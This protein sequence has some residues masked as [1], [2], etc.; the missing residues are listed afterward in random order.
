[1]IVDKYIFVLNKKLIV[2]L[3]AKSIS[4]CEG[5]DFFLF[6]KA[7]YDLLFNCVLSCLENSLFLKWQ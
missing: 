1:M 6:N 7:E 3:K 2:C 5:N 4:A